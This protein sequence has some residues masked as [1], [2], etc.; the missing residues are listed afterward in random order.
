[1]KS[2]NDDYKEIQRSLKDAFSTV[3]PEL[4]RD[5]WPAMLR[6][7]AAEP[8]AAIPWYDWVLAGCTLVLLALFPKLAWLVANH[9]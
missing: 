4:H 2:E 6:R 5:L 7:M 3:D 8:A 9:L 1:M